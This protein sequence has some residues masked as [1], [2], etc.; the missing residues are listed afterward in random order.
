IPS[1]LHLTFFR[2]ALWCA[3]VARAPK[4]AGHPGPLDRVLGQLHDSRAKRASNP[5]QGKISSRL[6]SPPTMGPLVGGLVAAPPPLGADGT[7]HVYL[8]C[9]PLGASELHKLQQAGVRIERLGMAPARGH[10]HRNTV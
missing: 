10:A 6:L 5:K 7:L 2:T 1:Q 3:T 9:A 4:P 8:E